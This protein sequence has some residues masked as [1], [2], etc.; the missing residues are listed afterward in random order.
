MLVSGGFA[1][2]SN[3]APFLKPLE[4]ISAFKYAYQ[5]LTHVEFENNQPINCI[6]TDNVLCDP[7]NNLFVFPESLNLS[8]ILMGIV[9]VC[10]EFLAFLII[11]L[12]ILRKL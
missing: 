5:T 11:Y 2:Q 3:F 12:K 1:S 4:Y 6:N 8:I 9:F 7:L 10:F